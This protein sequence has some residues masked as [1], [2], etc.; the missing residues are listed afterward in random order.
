MNGFLGTGA[1]LRADVNLLLQLAMGLLLLIGW[2]LAR[3]GHY[4]VH[5]YCQS[6]VML[7][8]LILIGLIML[9][10]LVRQ[11]VPNIP[12]KLPSAYYYLPVAHAALGTLAQVLGLYIVLAAGT[13]LLPERLRLRRYKPWMR[14]TLSLW[15]LTILLGMATY[16]FWYVAPQKTTAVAATD[17]AHIVI[18]IHNF[19]FTP[20]S[21]T[22]PVGTT[23]EWV[24]EQGQH[25]VNADDGAFKSAD[26]DAGTP[27]VRRFDEPGVFAYYCE[28]HG[29]KGGADMAGVITVVPRTP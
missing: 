28:Y 21:L 8:N 16:Y 13:R 27:Y 2:S 14:V 4:G 25:T 12:D 6:A 23:V 20:K 26:V 9:P 11:V 1:S 7:L 24:N 29:D 3:R 17:P 15:W 19:T 5:K 18:R 10:A 22:I